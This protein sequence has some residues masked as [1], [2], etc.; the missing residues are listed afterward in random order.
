[1]TIVML[2]TALPQTTFAASKQENIF[3]YYPSTDGYKSVEENYKDIDILAPQLYTVDWYLELSEAK[4]TDILKLA[5][6]KKIDVMPLVVQ[7][8]F[9]KTLMTQLLND[10]DAQED[11]IDDLIKEA[12]KQKY[13]GWQFDFENI[14]HLDRDK[15]TAFVKKAYKAFKKKRLKLSVAAVPRLKD[16][17]KNSWDQDWSSG[18]DIPALAKNSD[19]VSIMSYDQPNSYGPVASIDYVQKAIDQTLKDTPASKIS[20]G[21]PLYCW[22]WE[23]TAAGVT[24]KIA[25]LHYQTAAN[26]KEKYKNNSFFTT[27][28]TAAEAELF[29]FFK[30]DGSYHA[31]WCDNA[32]SLEAK[33]DL[34][35]KYKLRGISAWAIG[36]ED[37]EMWDVL[38]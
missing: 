6:K 15:Y 12:R 8:G 35:K 26:T 21:I 31:I 27:Y 29:S 28:S 2:G 4:S 13:I 1:M 18:T 5:K 22:Q 10:E 34:V 3:Y 33:Q 36:Q 24:K 38:K 25:N 16:Y 17:D 11:L 9:N 7:M 37:P 20:L 30:D 14:N 32:R 19:W 23:T